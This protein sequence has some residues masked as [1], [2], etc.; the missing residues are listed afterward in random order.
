[1]IKMQPLKQVAQ[2]KQKIITVVVLWTTVLFISCNYA[3]EKNLPVEAPA[4]K[5]YSESELTY[6]NVNDL[7]LF[8]KCVGCH[9]V[10]ART[11]LA[12][13]PQVK[14]N[15]AKIHIAV[16]VEKTMPKP[17]SP[18]LTNDELGL[19]NAW[20]QA[21]A[22][23]AVKN[24]PI[25]MPTAIP[26]APTFASIRHHILEPKCVGC[27]APGKSVARIPLVTLEDLLS[28]P[29]EI[30]IPENPDESGIMLAVLGLNPEKIMPP[31]KWPDGSSTGFAKLSEIEVDAIRMWI[32]NGA[33]D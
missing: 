30:V 5:N 33:K 2:M 27:H 24:D 22:P 20:I 23:E 31:L 17:G 1:M 19:L 4:V 3:V 6:K 21:G 26:L 25:P 9:G 14:T 32:K 15:L 10:S 16:F 18:V 13:Y 11:S 7:V 8:Q 28:S 29:L 12:T